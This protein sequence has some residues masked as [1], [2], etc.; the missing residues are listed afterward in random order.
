MLGSLNPSRRFQEFD[1]F[2][3]TQLE[4]R[5]LKSL[6]HFQYFFNPNWPFKLFIKKNLLTS[7]IDIMFQSSIYSILVNDKHDNVRMWRVIT[8]S[9]CH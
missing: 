6:T 5:H 8:Q 1:C 3:S 2:T 4:L 9:L 7:V